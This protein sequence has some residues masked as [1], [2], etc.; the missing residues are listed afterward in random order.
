MSVRSL[1]QKE[2]R[3]LWIYFIHSP[4]QQLNQTHLRHL[5]EPVTLQYIAAVWIYSTNN[6][7]GVIMHT[8]IF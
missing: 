6:I 3:S 2:I 1:A 4:L 8:R 7:W 5:A